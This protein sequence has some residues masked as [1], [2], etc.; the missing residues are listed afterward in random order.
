M[1]DEQQAGTS[2]LVEL[3]KEV[4]AEFRKLHWNMSGVLA[5]GATAKARDATPAPEFSKR[6]GV[7]L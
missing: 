4:R 5:R 7:E 2:G 6:E 3:A 1:T